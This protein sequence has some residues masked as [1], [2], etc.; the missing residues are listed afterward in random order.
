MHPNVEAIG[1]WRFH[2]RPAGHGARLESTI[3]VGGSLPTE[4]EQG[5]VKSGPATSVAIASGYASRVHYFWAGAGYEKRIARDG[6]QWGDVGYYSVVY[7]Y[8][9]P[10]L[11]LDY[12]KP[13]LRF[14]VEAQGENNGTR[15]QGGFVTST[16]AGTSC[17]SARRRCCST[18]NMGLRAASCSRSTNVP[19]A[20]RPANTTASSSTP[21]IS[22]GFTNL[23]DT[24]E[25]IS[26]A[27]LAALLLAPATAMAELRHVQLNVLG[28]D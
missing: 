9:P 21:A 20:P 25:K 3:F 26:A 22:S 2:T 27:L 14:F 23:E 18:S 4:S 24:C 12:P 19:T 13:D 28:M 15:A 5:G 1:G 16:P 7:G 8:R 17:W 10:F 6:D 11:Q